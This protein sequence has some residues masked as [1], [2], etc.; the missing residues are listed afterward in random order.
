MTESIGIILTSLDDASM[1]K[2][3]ARRLVEKR[4]AA[5]VQ[6]NGPGCSVY[7]W[8][9]ELQ[10]TD[11]YFLS[12]KALPEHQ[13]EIIR[14]LERHHPYDTPEVIV[15]QGQAAKAYADWVTQS[16]GMIQS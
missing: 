7:H 9:G 12:I 6:I 15:L 2:K 5:C 10:E 16:T 11:E 4:L 14:W 3:L 8:H 13:D 1:A